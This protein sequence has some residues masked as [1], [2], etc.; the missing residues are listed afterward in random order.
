MRYW[1]RPARTRRTTRRR[2]RRAQPRHQRIS[3]HPTRKPN[4]RWPVGPGSPR[5][6]SHGGRSPVTDGLLG[7]TLRGGEYQLREL[8][9]RGGQA[10]VYRAYARQ[11]ETDVAV[12]VHWY[13]EEA[14]VVYIV[15]RLVTGGTLKERLGLLGGTLGLTETA[16]VISDVADAL[17]HAHD[18]DVLHLD[19]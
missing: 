8:I 19:V 6:V 13:G 14:D 11:L 9:A 16:R 3:P 1:P 5:R 15:M 4:P 10:T 17:Q 12:E 18:H 2:L 7:R